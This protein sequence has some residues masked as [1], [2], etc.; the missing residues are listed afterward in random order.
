MIF[1]SPVDIH[2]SQKLR[3]GKHAREGRQRTLMHEWPVGQGTDEAVH[4]QSFRTGQDT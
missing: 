2:I 3:E 1:S 4:T